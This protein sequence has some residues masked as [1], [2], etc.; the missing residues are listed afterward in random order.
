MRY[1]RYWGIHGIRNSPE[2]SNKDRYGALEGTTSSFSWENM[3]SDPQGWSL[4]HGGG[5]WLVVRD[6]GQRRFWFARR[7]TLAE[8]PWG[9]KQGLPRPRKVNG[10][11]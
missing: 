2:H 10:K 6:I 5:G 8:G 3:E 9:R 1:T 4:I 7:E 11:G